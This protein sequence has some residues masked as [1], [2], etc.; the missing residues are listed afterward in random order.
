MTATSAPSCSTQPHLRT[1]PEQQ[2]HATRSSRIQR[3]SRFR[4]R[5]RAGKEAL[6]STSPFHNRALNLA[7]VTQNVQWPMLMG[8][9][10]VVSA[11]LQVVDPD[12]RDLHCRHRAYVVAMV[13]VAVFGLVGLGVALRL[14]PPRRPR[15]S[16][17]H[18]EASDVELLT[19]GR[20]GVYRRAGDVVA[21]ISSTSPQSWVTIPPAK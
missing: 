10:F 15:P 14:P 16:T 3:S 18:P 5:E 9:S 7:L 8:T 4:S 11:Y 17:P 19:S 6:L 20:S 12:G 13:V 21:P 1:P 2:F